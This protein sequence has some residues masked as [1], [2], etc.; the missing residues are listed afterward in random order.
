M[1]ANDSTETRRRSF[2]KL[3]G[4]GGLAAT[5]GCVGFGGGG[6][7]GSPET[8]TFGQPA[9]QTGQWDY[10][11]PGVTQ[12]TDAAVQ[13]I[14]EADGPLGAELNV[15]RRDTAVSP[16]EARTVVTQL[17]ENDDAAAL[18]GLFSSEI[19]PLF[20]FL[21]EQQIPI[22]TPWP[23][24]SFLDTRGGD[25][26]TPENLDD[27]GWIWRTVIGDTV[28]TSGAALRALDQGHQTMGVING[29]TEG[30][31]SWAEGF[32]SAY[33]D[34]DG[35][36]A[37]RVE[38]GQGQSNYQ[39][40]LDRLFGND[41]SAF[42]VSLPLEDATTLLSD[43][44]SGGYGRQPVLSDPLAQN[45]LVEQVGDSLSGAWAASPGQSGP[46]YDTFEQAYN[47][48]GNAEIN[49]W[50][51]PAWDAV[52]V[53]ALAVER[54]GE[55]TPEAIERN[56]GPVSRGGGTKVATFAEGKEELSNDNEINYTGAATPTT[57]TDFGNVFGSVVINVAQSSEFAE[58]STIPAQQVREFVAEDEY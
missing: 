56:L 19:N 3:A 5:A 32:I 58:E 49:A 15:V 39:A 47:N 22:V 42:A 11:Q 44:A 54:A 46:N 43:W 1:V 55:A 14:N 35:T 18:L 41:F 38:V 23:G 26:E 4:V 50:T 8:I 45:D 20:D 57:F 17:I 6:G 27:D 51:P 7:G 40:P 16:Q 2:L 12:A 53:T 9:A 31:R 30:A 28:H 33:E 34:G 29:T 24:S 25:K 52:H 10:L 13:S 21:Q 48:A 36:V 37:T